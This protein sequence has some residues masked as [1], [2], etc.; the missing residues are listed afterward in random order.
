MLYITKILIHPPLHLGVV[1]IENGAFWSPT[2]KVANFT[3]FTN[4][5]SNICLNVNYVDPM[6]IKAEKLI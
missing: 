3:Y 6:K 5:Y 4:R 2:T 1:D